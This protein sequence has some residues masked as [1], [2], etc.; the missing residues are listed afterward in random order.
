MAAMGKDMSGEDP[1]PLPCPSFYYVV[2]SV[3]SVCLP[4]SDVG[5]SGCGIEVRKA[6]A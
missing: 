2:D 6:R 5:F 3:S 1:Q 4:L